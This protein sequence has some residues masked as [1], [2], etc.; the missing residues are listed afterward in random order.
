MPDD[1]TELGSNHFDANAYL[2][3]LD[4]PTLTVGRHTFVGNFLGVEDWL[5]FTPRLER[6]A[7]GALG[8][9]DITRLIADLTNA[10]FR[11]PRW[12]KL[13][14]PWAYAELRKMPLHVQLK[15]LEHFI[16]SQAT[17]LNPMSEEPPAL[18]ETVTEAAAL[19]SSG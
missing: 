18:R 11:P 15:A 19:S 3:T 17:A 10:I 14:T 2:G 8:A 12:W 13:A 4:R 6:L 7:D 1:T 16:R 9:G 5:R